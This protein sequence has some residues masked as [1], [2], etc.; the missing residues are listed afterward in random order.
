MIIILILNAI[1]LYLWYILRY[2]Y[3]EVVENRNY[4]SFFNKSSKINKFL[5][6]K[7]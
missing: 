1:N 2:K 5:N 3:F 7:I 6:K 4:F